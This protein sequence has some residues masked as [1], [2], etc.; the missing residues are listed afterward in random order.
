MVEPTLL[1]ISL[2][3]F[4][5]A[6][7]FLGKGEAKGT[8]FATALVGALTIIAGIIQATV[9]NGPWVGALLVVYGFFYSSVAYALLTGLQ[10]MRSV[11][12]VSLTV[13]IISVVYV[14]LSLTGGPVLEGGKQLIPK[15]DYLALGCAG[16]TVLYIMVWLNSF[17]K[18]SAKA[19][20]W[21]LIVWTIVGLWIPGFWLLAT[22]KLP[23]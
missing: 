22:G 11:G 14:I 15:S 7:L 10:D 23:F 12:N 16:Y 13:A 4:P 21:S 5:V 2:M 8:G 19:L 6:L 20:A 18:F 17:G 1:A 3:W 9:F